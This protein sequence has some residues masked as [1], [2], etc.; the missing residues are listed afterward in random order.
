MT[1]KQL[2]WKLSADRMIK[3][4]TVLGYPEGF[5][6]DIAKIL[7]S[8]KA[9]DRMWAWLRFFRPESADMIA[10]EVLAIRSEIDAWRQKKSAQ[11]AN[12]RYNEIVN[13]GIDPEEWGEDEKG[14]TAPWNSPS[15]TAT[16][17]TS[18]RSPSTRTKKGILR[19]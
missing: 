1:E 13:Y 8:P 12:M 7:G 4:I 6:R 3:G 18:T 14:G 2:L 9:I 10:D 16:G 15:G 19:S 5:G 11:E 17:N